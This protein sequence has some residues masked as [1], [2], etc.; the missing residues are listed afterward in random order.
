[1][2]EKAGTQDLNDSDITDEYPDAISISSDNEPEPPPPSQKKAIQVKP[3][4][5]LQGP[6]V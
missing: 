2:N 3:E 5:G 6:I 1:M 4:P